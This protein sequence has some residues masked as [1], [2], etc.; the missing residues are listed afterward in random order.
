MAILKVGPKLVPPLLGI[1]PPGQEFRREFPLR[2]WISSDYPCVHPD[3]NYWYPGTRVLEGHPSVTM[4]RGPRVCIPL[5][6]CQAGVPGY[7]CAK[8]C[9]PYA[10]LNLG[11]LGPPRSSTTTSGSSWRP[12]PRVAGF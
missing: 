9:P 6:L 10:Y 5:P 11:L 12:Q 1:R 2:L 4:N 3:F 8:A 7:L